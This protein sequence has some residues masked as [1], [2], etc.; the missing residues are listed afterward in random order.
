MPGSDQRADELDR[1]RH[2]CGFLG[3]KVVEAK[4][5]AIL[6]DPIQEIELDGVTDGVGPLE[7]GLRMRE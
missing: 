6:R 1:V 2:I 4:I 3:W 7:P 5:A